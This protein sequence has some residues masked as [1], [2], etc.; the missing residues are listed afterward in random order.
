MKKIIL[1]FLMCVLFTGCKAPEGT[2]VEKYDI[3]FDTQG[4]ATAPEF[5]DDVTNIPYF[6][7]DLTCDGYDFVG[8]YY[9]KDCS[10]KV[11]LGKKINSDVILYAKWSLVTTGSFETP[12]IPGK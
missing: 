2:K 11:I 5:I 1:L 9:D 7:P 8:W 10:Q 3:Y 12:V 6:L 4:M